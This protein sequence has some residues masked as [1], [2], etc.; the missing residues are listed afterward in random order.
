[1]LSQPSLPSA[2]VAHRL[3]SAAMMRFRA[4][5]SCR[6]SRS[7]IAIA[8]LA[9]DDD[10]GIAS[11]SNTAS[12]FSIDSNALRDCAETMDSGGASAASSSRTVIAARSTP[13]QGG[14][15]KKAMSK[16]KNKGSKQ[17]KR[18]SKQKK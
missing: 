16:Q 5:S 17:E 18:R 11:P 6:R 3:R 9:F 14:Q 4:W 12:F 1:V 7:V 13:S 8:S 10:D 2:A 15:Q